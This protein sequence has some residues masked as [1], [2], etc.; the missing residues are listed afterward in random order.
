MWGIV[1]RDVKFLISKRKQTQKNHFLAKFDEIL[2]K[3]TIHKIKDYFCDTKQVEKVRLMLKLEKFFFGTL[4]ICP[5]K[6][7]LFAIV[8][9]FVAT[10]FESGRVV[11]PPYF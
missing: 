3:D 10:L 7:N 4:G 5:R 8:Q 6:K 11:Y 2:Q 1:W 9:G